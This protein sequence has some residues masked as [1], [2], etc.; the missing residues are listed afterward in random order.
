MKNCQRC[1][2]DRIASPFGKCSD[3]FGLQ[4]RGEDVVENDYVPC[5]FNI[6]DSDYIE[7]DYCL[8]CGQIQ[9]E[10]PISKEIEDL[11]RSSDEEEPP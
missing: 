10:F 5:G 8:D 4:I 9:G 1:G 6:G 3:A 11:L 2:S 7:F